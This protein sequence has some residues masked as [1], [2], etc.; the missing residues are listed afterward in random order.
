MCQVWF[1]LAFM[2]RTWV[3]HGVIPVRIPLRVPAPLPAMLHS[4]KCLPCNHAHT[5]SIFRRRFLPSLVH[6]DGHGE[7]LMVG[8]GWAIAAGTLSWK[9][10]LPALAHPAK[11]LP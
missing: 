10:M 9:H 11:H 1:I 2:V 8:L 4:A 5:T 6:F 7:E 3:C